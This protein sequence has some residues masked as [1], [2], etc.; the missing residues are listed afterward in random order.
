MKKAGY[1]VLILLISIL[2]ACSE[3]DGQETTT[4]KTQSVSGD[5]TITIEDGMGEVSLEGTPKRVVVL[6]WTYVEH[7]LPLGI[8][9][10][11]V[12]DVEGYNKW[13]NV[14]EPLSKSVKDVGT[15]AEPNLEAISRLNP[16]LI[17]GVK[18]RHKGILK[19]LQDIAPTVIFAPYS[20]EGVK[21]QYQHMLD[22]FHTIAKI[23]D[24]QKKAD[25]VEQQ[26]EQTFQEQGKRI[27]DAGYE[28]L[29]A[30]VTQAFTSQNAPVLRL[31]TDNSVVAGVL[32]K[33]GVNNAVPSDKPEKYGFLS[34]SVEALQNY[35]DN[36]FF[37]LV[38]E[39][40]T[41]FSKQLAGNPAWTNL[42]FVKENHTYK[43]PGDMGTFAGPLSAKRLSV[44]FADA[45]VNKK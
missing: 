16:D 9:P 23:F 22:E 6:E 10:I 41:I 11:G 44:E 42:N 21:N 3:K 1:I 20:E 2:T 15:R 14:G 7:L 18:Y 28:K 5:K 4:S 24:K 13:I 12:S 37:Y 43:L 26:L 8:E 25:E 17:I 39:D 30:V 33:M 32:E 27:T 19:Q 29:D 36:H 40:D 35:Q 34:V 38:Q 31:F 45:L